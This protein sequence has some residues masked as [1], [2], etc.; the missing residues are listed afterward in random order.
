M[1][2]FICDVEDGLLLRF[3]NFGSV[4]LRF[5]ILH[6]FLSLQFVVCNIDIDTLLLQTD[7]HPIL[8]GTSRVHILIGV[9][10][11]SKVYLNG[12]IFGC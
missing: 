3:K 5:T 10:F 2:L 12:R 9:K 7:F 4:R 11:V 8:L 6:K 1:I